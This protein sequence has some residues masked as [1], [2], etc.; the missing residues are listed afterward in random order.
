[1][2]QM[3]PALQAAVGLADGRSAG[4]LAYQSAIVRN[5]FTGADAP[6]PSRYG[7]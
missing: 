7:D 3:E 4:C 1:M 6:V 2:W 5:H